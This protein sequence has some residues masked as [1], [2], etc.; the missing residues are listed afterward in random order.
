V[1]VFG[2]KAV[3]LLRVYA[4]VPRSGP[5]ALARPTSCTTHLTPTMSTVDLADVESCI[6]ST[7][8]CLGELL[9]RM[10]A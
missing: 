10:A 2:G 3:D 4:R 8:K 6:L 1:N 7:S 9:L 5:H